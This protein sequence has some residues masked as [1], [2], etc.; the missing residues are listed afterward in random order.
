MFLNCNGLPQKRLYFKRRIS[1][2]IKQNLSHIALRTFLFFYLQMLV[3]RDGGVGW[4]GGG[5]LGVTDY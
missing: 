1:H 4:G 5:V 2:N 3:S